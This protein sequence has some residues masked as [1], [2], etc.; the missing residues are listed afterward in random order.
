MDMNK[1]L[2]AVAEGGMSVDEFVTKL[3]EQ[4]RTNRLK[5]EEEARLAAEAEKKA[6]REAETARAHY[7]TEIANKTLAHGL[8]ASDVAWLIR[9]YISQTHPNVSQEALNGL[10]DAE[11]VDAIVEAAL[12]TLNIFSS[13][14]PFGALLSSL[15]DVST[16]TESKSEPKKIVVKKVSDPDEIL[17]N[18]VKSLK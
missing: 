2:A 13:K 11:G 16:A 15:F 6:Q 3:R 14:N 12:E 9:E 1:I 10:M 8:E 18:F 4:E 17:R 7:I 5:A